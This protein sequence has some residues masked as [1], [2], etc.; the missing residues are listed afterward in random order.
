MRRNWFW[1][2]IYL[3]LSPLNA[4]VSMGSIDN[5]VHV[6]VYLCMACFVFKLSLYWNNFFVKL[7]IIIPRLS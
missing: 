2:L 3:K 4:M 7:P 1:I 6:T 5:F